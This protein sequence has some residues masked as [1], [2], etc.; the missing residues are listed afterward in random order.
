MPLHYLK[1]QN[2]L[3]PALSA[4]FTMTTETLRLLSDPLQVLKTQF[5]LDVV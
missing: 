3:H 5:A 1:L 4:I 2:W